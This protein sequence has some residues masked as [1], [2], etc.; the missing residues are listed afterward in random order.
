MNLAAR[1]LEQLGVATEEILYLIAKSRD[2]HYRQLRGCFQGAEPESVEDSE[3]PR[4][5]TVI[6]HPQ[7]EAVGTRIGALELQSVSVTVD[8]VR[9]G[10]IRGEDPIPDMMLQAGDALILRGTPR[11]LEHAEQ[12]LLAG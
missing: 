11:A 4:L 5:H 9:R 1:L 10:A 12:M 8:A 6:L 2:D 3:R 7:S